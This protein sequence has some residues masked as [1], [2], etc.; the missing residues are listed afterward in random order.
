MAKNQEEKRFEFKN[1]Y[2]LLILVL[3]LYLV[4]L[5]RDVLVPF[6]LGGLLAYALT[7]I[8]RRLNQWGLS[9]KLS[10]VLVFLGLLV[11][12]ALL[13]FLIIPEALSQLKA[14]A[15]SAPE[16][17][18]EFIGKILEI[19]KALDAKYPDLHLTEAIEDFL[20]NIVG[21]FENYLQGITRNILNLVSLFMTVLFLGFI[22]TPFALYYFMVDAMKVRR[23]LVRLFP[24]NRR[25]EYVLLLRSIDKV[26]GSF[27]RGRLILS[28]FVG[29][30]VTTGLLIM[31][32][33][34]P[35]VIGIIAG[36]ADIIPYLG[37]IVGAIPALLFASTKSIWHVIGVI[38]LFSGVNFVEGV[39]VTP[40]VMGKE[41]GLHPVTVL[42]ALLVGGKLFG[43][44]GVIAAI[45]VA[46]VIKGILLHRRKVKGS[47][48]DL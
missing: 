17:I 10:V 44:L 23:A 20:R 47:G 34:F 11:F 32:I 43:A 21:N 7:P 35:L 19:A 41:T 2:Y 33:E 18:E 4:Y 24:P 27:I 37:P 42:F 9:W 38:A 3:T 48:N 15:A 46:G 5:L 40:R 8:A 25:K 26:V 45:P 28:L 31:K 39:V 16:R 6:V 12:F 22:V 1:L 13:F 29:V 36:I 14:F 30:T